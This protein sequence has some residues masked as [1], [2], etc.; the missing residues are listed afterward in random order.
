MGLRDASA[1]KNILGS[2]KILSDLKKSGSLTLKKYSTIV[3][4]SEISKNAIRSQRS[5]KMLLDLKDLKKYSSTRY[6]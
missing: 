6:V 3:W 1:S 2:Q 4:I 5:Q